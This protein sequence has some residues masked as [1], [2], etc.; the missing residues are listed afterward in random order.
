LI[1]RLNSICCPWFVDNAVFQI[2]K[3]IE[4][5]NIHGNTF[6]RDLSPTQISEWA[7]EIS[8]ERGRSDKSGSL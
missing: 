7:N 2:R 6:Q 4:T 8:L 1:I 3:L 5:D